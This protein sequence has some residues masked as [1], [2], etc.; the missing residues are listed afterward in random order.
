MKRHTL[1][2]LAA[3]DIVLVA[4][5][6][7]LWVN[8][9]GQWRNIHWSPPAAIAPDYSQTVPA[10][11][12]PAPV[13]GSAYAAMLDRPLFSP[14]RRR[15]P[16]PAV[17]APVVD[18]LGDAQVLGIFESGALRGV[19]VRAGGQSRRVR[20]NEDFN[21]WQLHAVTE[22]A[23]VFKSG[24]QTRE[25]PLKRA[26]LTAARAAPGVP[27]PAGAPRAPTHPNPGAPAGSRASSPASANGT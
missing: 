3:L 11:P 14:S 4:V 25:L 1:M 12:T 19:I 10:L 5:L 20:L 2:A 18:T 23:A 21:G 15:A 27:R 26:D 13:P 8:A 16:A 24:A 22:R 9:R 6:L 17:V 7:L